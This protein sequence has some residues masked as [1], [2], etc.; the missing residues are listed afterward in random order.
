MPA[1]PGT[2]T[3]RLSALESEVDT[4]FESELR[5]ST[6]PK[7]A[8]REALLDVTELLLTG[9]PGHTCA[10]AETQPATN[11]EDAGMGR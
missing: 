4:A 1:A 11:R 7:G 10:A 6:I 8:A 2:D 9:Q 3:T 5:L